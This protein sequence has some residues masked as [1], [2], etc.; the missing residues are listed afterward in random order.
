MA[1]DT[2]TPME[3][4]EGIST[5]A[6]KTEAM[7]SS[8]TPAGAVTN[9]AEMAISDEEEAQQA[10]EMLRGDEVAERIA[11]ANKLERVAKTL[12]DERTREVREDIILY[13]YYAECILCMHRRQ[14]FSD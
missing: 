12:G 4:D 5:I 11:A 13:A 9:N 8:A 7:D 14:V 10:I 1:V 6:T 2:S 3:T